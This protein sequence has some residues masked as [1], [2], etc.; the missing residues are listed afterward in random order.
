MIPTKKMEKKEAMKYIEKT[1]SKMTKWLVKTP[2]P[3]TT[4]CQDEEMIW[5]DDP[6]IPQAQD[7]TTLE[8]K[9]RQG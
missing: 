3:V 5:E 8:K 2:T 1:N 9:K 4:P 6:S 7:V